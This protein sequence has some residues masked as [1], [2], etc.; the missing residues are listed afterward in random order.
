VQGN[1]TP[2]FFLRM[3]HAPRL[4]S[5]FDAVRAGWY[6]NLRGAWAPSICT[7]SRRSNAVSRYKNR[8]VSWRLQPAGCVGAL[9]VYHEPPVERRVEVQEPE[10]S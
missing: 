4:L 3:G 7:T 5:S 6:R 9:S 1:S 8:N 10:R 2:D